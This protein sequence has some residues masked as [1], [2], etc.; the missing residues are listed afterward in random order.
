MPTLRPM[1]AQPRIAPTAP[2]VSPDT[3]RLRVLMAGK[4]TA[5]ESPG[6]GEV[7]MLR[8]QQSLRAH[9]VDATLWRPWEQ[10]LAEADV[11]HLFGSQPEHVELAES[12]RRL[13]IPVVLSTVAWFD[14]ASL[15][16]ERWSL[17]RRL[18]A[19]G[20]YLFR[21]AVPSW[22][23]WRRR[24]YHL[25]DR[26]LPN[27]NVESAQLTRLFQVPTQ[28]IRAV[29][30]GADERFA[31]GDPALAHELLGSAEPFVLYCGRIEP[32]KNQLG[33]LRALHG[34]D[35][36]IV[37]VGDAVS[38]EQTY[39]DECR[40]VAGRRVKF[41]GRVEHDSPLLASLYAACGCLV[42]ASWFETPGLVALEAGMSGVP[43]VLPRGG[44]AAEYFGPLATYVAPRDYGAIREQTL[45]A[46]RQPRNPLLAQLVH[47]NFSWQA[48][49]QATRE[50]YDELV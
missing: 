14:L 36:P 24:L 50:V 23:S 42:L 3:R 25:C 2:V 8:T 41:L 21:A 47:D 20:R 9:G 15:W 18:A 43:L 11:L 29:P 34:V 17:S 10:R 28:R 37:I 30:N 33:F 13:N 26:L 1:H 38:G 31:L 32:R 49:A 16:H 6:G 45:R 12:A 7:Q 27:S 22:P 46:L 44:C 19:C 39:L 35:V 5:L 48:T 40:R 4:L